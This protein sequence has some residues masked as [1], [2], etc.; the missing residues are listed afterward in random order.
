[1]DITDVDGTTYHPNIKDKQ[2]K[3]KQRALTYCSKE[4]P[5]PLCYNMDIKEET[6]ARESHS[7]ILT[8]RLIDGEATLNQLVEEGMIPLN[9]YCNW[10]RGLNAYK[11]QKQLEKEKLPESLPNP[12]DLDLKILNDCK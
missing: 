3:N 9:Q 8:K 11:R 2:I 10:E 4:D 7:K 5:D 6:K 1:M 12:W